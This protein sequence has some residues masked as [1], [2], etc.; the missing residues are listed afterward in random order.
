MSL[1]TTAIIGLLLASYLSLI[2]TQNVSVAR[3]QAWN[4]S[5]AVVRT[6]SRIEVS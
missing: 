5:I 1:M 4:V 2:Q 6:N 3:S